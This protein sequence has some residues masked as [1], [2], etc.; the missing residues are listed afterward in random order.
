MHGLTISMGLPPCTLILEV[1]PLLLRK[2]TWNLV[3]SHNKLERE[4][5][6]GMPSNMAMHKPNTGIVGVESDYKI[7]TCG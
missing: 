1:I 4:P 3:F 7:S 5:L 6:G 2:E